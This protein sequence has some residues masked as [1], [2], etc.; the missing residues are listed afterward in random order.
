M[1]LWEMSA[2]EILSL[3]SLKEVSA[4]EVVDSYLQR[5]YEIEPEIN[6]YIELLE[7]EARL[8]AEEV[9]AKRMRNESPGIL[10]GIPV[11][12]KDNICLTGVKC[13][14][15]SEILSNWVAPYDATVVKKLKEQGAVILGKNNMDEFAMGSSTETSTFGPTR[16]PWDTRRVPGGSSGGSAAA[17]AAGQACMAFGTDTGGSVRQPAAFT[18]I[19]GFK[20]TYGLVSRCGVVAL[21]VP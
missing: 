9:D 16:N 14:C 19:Y 20:P 7:P 11:A 8:Q 21:A 15:A 13:T 18:G 17:V 4:R 1:E 2:Q 5:I 10:G 6:A 3:L 12:L